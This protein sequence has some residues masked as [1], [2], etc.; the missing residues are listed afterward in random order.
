MKT[1]VQQTRCNRDLIVTPNDKCLLS[2][3]R[4]AR[5]NAEKESKTFSKSKSFYVD[6]PDSNSMSGTITLTGL[7][8]TREHS[9]QFSSTHKEDDYLMTLQDAHGPEQM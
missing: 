5:A 4:Q 3:M 7:N 9:K 2:S 1:E 6:D 8:H